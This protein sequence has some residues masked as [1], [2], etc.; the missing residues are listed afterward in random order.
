MGACSVASVVSNFLQPMG[1]SLPHSSVGR[2][3]Q[4]GIL[5]WVAM[6]YSGDL[7]NPAIEPVCPADPALKVILYR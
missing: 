5:K 2:I 6:P 1:C 4:A 7:S 3:S